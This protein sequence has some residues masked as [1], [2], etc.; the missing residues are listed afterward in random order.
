[1]AVAKNSSFIVRVTALGALALM[2]I[3]VIICLFIIFRP[4]APAGPT[5][6][7]LEDIA[8]ADVPVQKSNTGILAL[9]IVFLIAVFVLVLIF[10]LREQK[11]VQKAKKE[12]EKTDW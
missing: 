3:A 11:L 2:I 8:P 10:S 9:F 6:M 4:P 1:M 12:E 5:L 7:L